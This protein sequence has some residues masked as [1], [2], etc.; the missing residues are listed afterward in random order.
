MGFIPGMQ[1][2]YNT[3]KPINAQYHINKRKDKNY[4]FIS[5]NAEKEFDKI[6]HPFII[7]KNTWQSGNRRGIL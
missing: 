2:R 7:K 5:I 3:Y 1:G 6:Q 4:K